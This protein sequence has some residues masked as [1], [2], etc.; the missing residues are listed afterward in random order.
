MT[1]NKLKQVLLV[2]DDP[3]YGYLV[4]EALANCQSPCKL[5]AL[6]SGTDLLNWLETNG[7]PTVIF[8]DINMPVS[9]GF[10]ILKLLKSVDRYKAI[11]VVMLS[12]SLQE[13]DIRESYQIGANAYMIKPLTPNLLKENMNLFSHYWLDVAQTPSS[14]WLRPNE[15][16]SYD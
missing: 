4:Q 2:D 1:M 7:R 15:Y 12:V 5:T 3:D 13:A 11:P 10:D 14:S 16:S 6:L 9:N 8:L